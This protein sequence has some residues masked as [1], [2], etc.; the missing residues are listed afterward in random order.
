MALI[1][2]MALAVSH[3]TKHAIAIQFSNGTTGQNENIHSHT[4]TWMFI[5]LLLDII[6]KS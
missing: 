3:K 1:L 2:E 6:T 4:Y 5:A